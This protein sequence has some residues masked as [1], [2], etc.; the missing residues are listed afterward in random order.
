MQNADGLHLLS[1]VPAESLSSL[2]GDAFT[3]YPLR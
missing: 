1:G 3:E 2:H